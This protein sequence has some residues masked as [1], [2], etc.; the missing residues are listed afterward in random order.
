MYERF[1]EILAGNDAILQL[2]AE[3]DEPPGRRTPFALEADD[4]GGYARRRM[5]ASSW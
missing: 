4:A 2:I 1:R 5:E 3:I